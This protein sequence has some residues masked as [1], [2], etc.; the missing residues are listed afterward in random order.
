MINNLLKGIE[1]V[2]LEDFVLEEE[3]PADDTL[4]Y[5]EGKSSGEVEIFNLNL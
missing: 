5:D 4:N 3:K 1:E 2:R